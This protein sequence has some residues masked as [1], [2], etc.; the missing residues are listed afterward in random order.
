MTPA[1]KIDEDATLNLPKKTSETLEEINFDSDFSADDGD[2]HIEDDD[3]LNAIGALV[4]E[5]TCA[6][7]P[8]TAPMESEWLLDVQALARK[9]GRFSTAQI[10]KTIPILINGPL[11]LPIPADD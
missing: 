8:I 11:P 6:G 7:L 9:H 4:G 3:V 1:L 2:E 5:P 10:M